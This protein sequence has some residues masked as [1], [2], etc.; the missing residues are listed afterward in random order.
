MSNKEL[1]IDKNLPNEKKLELLEA[2]LISCGVEVDIN[3][4]RFIAAEKEFD[5]AKDYCRLAR[6]MMNEIEVDIKT[7]KTLIKE[8]KKN[9]GSK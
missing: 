7:I 6:R 8:D 1:K 3:I 2:N 9:N 5:L 4:K